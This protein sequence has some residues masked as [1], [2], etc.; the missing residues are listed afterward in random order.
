MTVQPVAERGAIYMARI[1]IACSLCASLLLSCAG[2]LGQQ[3]ENDENSL[4]L[5]SI[6]IP[7]P[8]QFIFGGSPQKFIGSPAVVDPVTAMAVPE[9]PFMAPN[10]VSSLHLNGYQTDTYTTGGPLGRAPEV[11]STFL[12][13]LCGTVTFDTKGRIEVVCINTRP[14]LYILDPVSL[15]MLAKMP[16]P[17]NGG[18]GTFGAGGYFFTDQAGRAVIPTRTHDVWRVATVDSASGPQL[19]L[20]HSCGDSLT[21]KIP[22]DQD[23]LSVFPDANGLLWVTTSGNLDNKESAIVFTVKPDES[24]STGCAV[25]MLTLPAGEIIKKSFAVDPDPSRGGVFIV[26]DHKL[27]RFDASSTGAPAV[28]WSQGY[29][30][31][32]RIKPGQ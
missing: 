20:D 16:L 32:V 11:T 10:G 24:Q 30:R 17:K 31:G 12:A 26:S 14:V 18:N 27:Y 5:N 23:I 8:Q 21:S 7:I 15:Q 25:Q 6:V 4:T 9:S 3:T 1:S 28:T 2:A 13:A 22:E 19:V 29:N